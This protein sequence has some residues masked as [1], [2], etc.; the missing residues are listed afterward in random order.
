MKKI[1]AGLLVLSLVFAL[2]GCKAYQEADN[3][4][5]PKIGS[6]TNDS[7]SS[8]Y[9]EASKPNDYGQDEVS[10]GTKTGMDGIDSL[11]Q[12]KNATDD[13]VVP[14][15]TQQTIP[16]TM[17]KDVNQRLQNVKEALATRKNAVPGGGT[18]SMDSMQEPGTGT[19]SIES[20][21][22]KPKDDTYNYNEDGYNSSSGAD[23][24]G[25]ADV[26]TGTTDGIDSQQQPSKAVA[27]T[28]VPGQAQKTVVDPTTAKEINKDL[29][30]ESPSQPGADPFANKN[31]QTKYTQPGTDE[32]FDPA[33]K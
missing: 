7:Y 25:Q 24:F 20:L 10:T 3:T 13:V 15:Q 17:T 1:T 12:S 31:E 9:N 32:A 22:S 4:N 14:G 5:G 26:S 29:S 16:P 30:N 23:N 19:S 33:S 28:V 18:D 21:Q 2:M 11:Q 6:D 27:A 8:S